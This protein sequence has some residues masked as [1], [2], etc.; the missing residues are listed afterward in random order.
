[1]ASSINLRSSNSITVL[2][3]PRNF[4][5][6]LAAQL[7]TLVG[8][9]A[10]IEEDFAI[11]QSKL[12][13]FHINEMEV[14]VKQHM[15]ETEAIRIEVTDFVCNHSMYIATIDLT[16]KDHVEGPAGG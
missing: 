15:Q 14:L 1:L 3:E 2:F 10:K 11:K 6:P 9:V 13:E 8:K 16:G 5:I 12:N 7:S 4:T